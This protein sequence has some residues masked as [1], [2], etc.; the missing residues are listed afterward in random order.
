YGAHPQVV[1]ASATATDPGPTVAKF[2]GVPLH[3]V[4]VID[5][6]SAPQG[7][8]TV[9][10]W[11]PPS[12]PEGDQS[13]QDGERKKSVFAE[14][15]DMLTTLVHHRSSTLVFT[16]SRA[17]AE[18][19]AE[20]TRVG[21]PHHL[22]SRVAAYRGGFLPEERRTIE[23]GLR[24]GTL[25]GVVS[26]SALEMGVDIPGLDAVIIAG[27]PGTWSSFWQQVGRT[28]RA[29]TEGIA[30]FIASE[31][32]LDHYLLNHPQHVFSTPVEA[33]VFDPSNPHIVAPHLCAAAAEAPLTEADLPGFGLSDSALVDELVARGLLRTRPQG[34]LWNYDRPESAHHL[35]DLRGDSGYGVS[36]V[37]QDTGRVVGT[38]DSSRADATVHPGAVYVHQGH[39]Y[40]V[41]DSDDE[42]AVVKP[43]DHPLRTRAFTRTRVKILSEQDHHV[44]GDLRWCV[45]DIEVRSHVVSYQARRLPSM[46]VVGTYPLTMPERMLRTQGVWWTLPAQVLADN[47]VTQEEL[48]GALHAAEHAMISLL[49]LVATCDR[50]DMGG[51]STAVHESTLDP[52]VFVY[53][54]FPG[55]AG[56]ARR[57]FDAAHTWVQATLEAVE[58]CPCEQG[59]PRC[60]QSPK[61]GNGN[62]PLHKAG[63]ITTLKVLM[64]SFTTTAPPAR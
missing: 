43:T 17:G 59:C 7:Q 13:E 14:A 63:A 52:T 28:A 16:G 51:L 24:S 15:A 20:R 38:V 48:P 56:F 60:I 11:D 50:W 35:T 3:E 41:V 54:A 49:G 5:Q 31:N 2:L 40:T 61:C 30:V 19:I 57:G 22:H 18:A 12:I 46:E 39:S 44:W 1:V 21:L 29:G 36:V 9:V 32:P 25:L 64:A 27:W 23:Q 45:G 55:G 4:G 8:R 37:E 34:W 33:T 47:G 58:G 10:L 53:D 42:V 6:S 26:T 62:S